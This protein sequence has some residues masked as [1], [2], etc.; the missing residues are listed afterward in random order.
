MKILLQALFLI[1]LFTPLVAGADG[2][3]LLKQCST[4]LTKIQSKKSNPNKIEPDYCLGLLQGIIGSEIIHKTFAD[5]E[6]Y[7]KIRQFCAPNKG[8]HHI[9]AARIVVK[10]LKEHPAALKRNEVILSIMALKAAFP[11]E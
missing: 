6:S 10:Y 4:T 3:K 11:C 7:K 8:I 2:N 9:H 5:K 1:T